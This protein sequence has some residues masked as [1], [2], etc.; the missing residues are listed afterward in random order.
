M[1]KK[2]YCSHRGFN[3]IAPENTLPAFGAA[4]ALGADEIELD[5]WPS[6]DGKIMVCHDPSID[7]TT[8]KSG[9]IIDLTSDKIR[10]ADAGIGMS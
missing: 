10:E 3:S 4:A 2:I 7:R 1:K 6:A 5:L 8:N 9:K